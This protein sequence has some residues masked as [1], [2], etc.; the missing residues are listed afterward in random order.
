MTLKVK[1]LKEGNTCAGKT[2]SRKGVKQ[3]MRAFRP[4]WKSDSYE[5]REVEK[6]N[7]VENALDGSA[8]VR[9]SWPD[10]REPQTGS[11]SVRRGLVLLPGAWEEQ[12]IPQHLEELL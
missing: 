8:I 1:V 11:A 6:Y 2:C 10:K 12:W 7:G 3:T 5:K 4:Q 9:V